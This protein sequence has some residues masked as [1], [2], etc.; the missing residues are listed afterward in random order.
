MLDLGLVVD[1][2]IRLAGVEGQIILVVRLR[3]MELLQRG[4]LGHDGFAEHTIRGQFPDVFNC[5]FLL[6]GIGK[7][8]G[9]TVLAPDIRALPVELGRVVGDDKEDL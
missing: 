8:N 3:G 7:E 1:D 6:T 5:G 9:R 4:D 2:D